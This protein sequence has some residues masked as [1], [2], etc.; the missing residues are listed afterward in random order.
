MTVL[1]TGG[2]GY[3]GSHTVRALRDA[4][5]DVVV[6]DSLELGRRA[7][8]CSTRRSSSATS[9]TP[10]SS[11][12]VCRDHGVTPI[13]HFA[14]YKSVGESME[15]ARASTGATTSTARS[16]L[17]EAAMRG[18]RPRHRVLV[19]VLGVRHAGRRC[20]SSRSAPIQPESVYAETKAMVERILRWY[21]VTNGLRVGEPALLQRRRRQLRRGDRRGLDVLDQPHPARDEG[22]A[23]RGDRRLQVFGDDY[24]TPDGTCIRDY[25]HVDDLADAHVAGARLPRRRRRRARS[26]STS[27]PASARRCSR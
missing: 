18:R 6:L 12:Q 17:V 11:T 10:T 21:G 7:T 9:P 14:A 19:V 25:I 5:R 8:P 4:G 2:A 20:R 24:A 15:S 22:R 26:R 3:I 13:V 27:A 16:T 1:V 23:R